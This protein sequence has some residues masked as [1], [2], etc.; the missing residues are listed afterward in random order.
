MKKHKLK[1]M[2]ILSHL[3]KCFSESG[4]DSGEWEVLT[5]PF[6]LYFLFSQNITLFNR[7]FRLW[8][9]NNY[10]NNLCKKKKRKECTY[11][12]FILRIPN[13]KESWK[14]CV[15]YKACILA[16]S[17]I[18]MSSPKCSDLSQCSF[19]TYNGYLHFLCSCC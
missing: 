19:T 9:T 17:I 8:I 18:L 5:K 1:H 2:F 16:C 12:G 15:Q 4:P 3:L 7:G 14:N 11:N 6:S 10:H 13:N